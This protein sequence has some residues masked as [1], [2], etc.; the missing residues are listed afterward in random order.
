[1]GRDISTGLLYLV[2]H[3]I[4]VSVDVVDH[5]EIFIDKRLCYFVAQVPLLPVC[6][7]MRRRRGRRLRICQSSC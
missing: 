7:P 2:E 3:A 5:N 1:M 4:I 6:L